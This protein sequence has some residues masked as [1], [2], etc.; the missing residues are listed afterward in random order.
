MHGPS[1]DG[2]CSAALGDL[3]SYYESRLLAAM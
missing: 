1:F 3:A 2:D